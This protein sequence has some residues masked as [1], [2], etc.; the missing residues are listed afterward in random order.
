MNFDVTQTIEVQYKLIFTHGLVVF[1]VLIFLLIF[2]KL[3]DLFLLCRLEISKN[4]LLSLKLIQIYPS[5]RLILMYDFAFYKSKKIQDALLASIIC[6]ILIFKDS[7][8]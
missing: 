2:F 8:I 5:F 1:N 7:H 6:A 4:S 3:I